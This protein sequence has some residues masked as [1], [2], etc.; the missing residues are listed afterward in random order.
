MPKEESHYVVKDQYRLLAEADGKTTAGAAANVLGD[1]VNGTDRE[2]DRHDFIGSRT[3]RKLYD[4]DG[5]IVAGIALYKF[6]K[7]IQEAYLAMRK[8]RRK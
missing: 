2:L 3:E 1:A 6:F 7:I 5:N 4:S 8:Q